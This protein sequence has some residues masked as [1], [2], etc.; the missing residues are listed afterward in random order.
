VL[1]VYVGDIGAFGELVPDDWLKDPG[2]Q[3]PP[4]QKRLRRFS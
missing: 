2:T 1:E 4:T 3:R